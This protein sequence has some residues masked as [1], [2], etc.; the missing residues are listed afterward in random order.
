MIL[1]P[2]TSMMSWER[3]RVELV[4]QPV[5]QPTSGKGTTMTR[6]FLCPLISANS[7][8]HWYLAYT[9]NILHVCK[10]VSACM[11][12]CMSVCLSACMHVCIIIYIYA[13]VVLKYVIICT[14]N[15]QYILRLWWD[16]QTSPWKKFEH[17]LRQG[18]APVPAPGRFGP[19]DGSTKQYKQWKWCKIQV[20][21]T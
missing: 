14:P 19:R 1:G 8:A 17:R 5:Y 10:Y 7:F 6:I 9:Y 3:W 4:W 13:Y 12:A 15:I 21:S 2:S 16:L 11:Y 20:N 18:R